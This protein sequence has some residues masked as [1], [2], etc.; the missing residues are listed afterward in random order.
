MTT[1]PTGLTGNPDPTTAAESVTERLVQLAKRVDE[2]LGLLHDV[3]GTVKHRVDHLISDPPTTERGTSDAVQ[4][5]D[6]PLDGIA[7]S[8]S[9][10]STYRQELEY[11]A[12]RL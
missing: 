3:I 2:E 6:S 12:A 5:V 4:A 8:I 7:H 1:V 10:L 11:Y 9:R